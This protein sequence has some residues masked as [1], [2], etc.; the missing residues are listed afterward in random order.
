MIDELTDEQMRALID[1]CRDM[2][3]VMPDDEPDPDD[4]PTEDEPDAARDPLTEA[5]VRW[6]RAFE[7]RERAVEE[8]R[9]AAKAL[10]EVMFGL[11]LAGQGRRDPYG[12]GEPL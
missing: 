12:R 10:A 3:P 4:A 1:A 2:A 8:Q 11:P 7:A 5:L 9:R 6:A